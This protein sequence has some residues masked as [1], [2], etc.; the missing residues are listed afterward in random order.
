MNFF[1]HV[2]GAEATDA[3]VVLMLHGFLGSGADWKLIA[4]LLQPPC[5]CYCPDLPGHGQTTMLDGAT[6]N[7]EKTAML[8]LEDLDSLGIRVCALSGYSMGGRLALYLAVTSPDRFRCLVLESA[9]PGLQTQMERMHRSNHDAILARDLTH[10]ESG[11]EAFQ[12]F[13]QQWYTQPIFST[14]RQRPEQLN[15][16]IASRLNNNPKGLASSL[17]SMGTG[18]QPGLWEALDAV[19]IPTLLLAGAE[20][21]KFCLLGEKMANKMSQAALEILQ[22]CSHNIHFEQPEKYATVLSAFFHAHLNNSN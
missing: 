22:D 2:F 15:A 8:L 14:L 3:P 4:T 20:D 9:S 5:R 21:H 6:C 10:M 16:L 11:C 7:I 17:I 13:L 1:W 12:A 19:H 18:A